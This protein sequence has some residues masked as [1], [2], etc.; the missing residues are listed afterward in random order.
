MSS[1]DCCK[2]GGLREILQD[3]DVYRTIEGLLVTHMCRLH[4]YGIALHQVKVFQDVTR[5]RRTTTRFCINTYMIISEITQRRAK[6]AEP[7]LESASADLCKSSKSDEELGASNLA[8][9]KSQGLRSRKSKVKHTIKGK[10][11]S[12]DGDKV[13]GKK[14]G[15]PLPDWD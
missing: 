8:S 1:V 12:I 9:C 11:Q 5:T 4:C 14:Y 13:K 7:E 15:G 3:Q 6:P 10:R 2:T